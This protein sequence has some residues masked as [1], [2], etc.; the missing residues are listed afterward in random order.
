M[1][2]Q[3]LFS[4]LHLLFRWIHILAGIIWLGLLYFFNFVNIPLQGS[5]SEEAKK[6][7]NPQMMPRALWWFRWAAMFTFLAGLTLFTMKYMYTPGAGF[8]PTSLFVT[9]DGMTARAVWIQF[10]MLFA[11]IMW[12]NVWF[13][14]WPAQKKLLSGTAGE[15]AASLKTRA[16]KAS[17]MNTFMSGPMLFGMIAPNHYGAIN[18][19][20]FGVIFA[21]GVLVIFVCYKLS[22]KVGV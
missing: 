8:G 12:F 1:A 16:T 17:R 14:I 5:L 15:A 11:T 2:L 22:H 18:W 9:E 19:V 3:D 6:S 4:N 20:T 7:V 10:G 21:V 13:I